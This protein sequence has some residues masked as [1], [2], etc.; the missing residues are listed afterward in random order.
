MDRTGDRTPVDG[1]RGGGG[2]LAAAGTAWTIRFPSEFGTA[3]VWDLSLSWARASQKALCV[4]KLSLLQNQTKHQSVQN[5]TKTKKIRKN[6]TKSAKNKNTKNLENKV[7]QSHLYSLVPQVFICAFQS[8]CTAYFFEH[9]SHF[10]FFSPCFLQK[11]FLIPVR[12]PRALEGSWW[13]Q[14]DSGQT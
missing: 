14:A 11:C 3:R 7:P 6:V 5:W 4:M 10:H 9:L 12:S 1:V 13:T 2:G 8:D